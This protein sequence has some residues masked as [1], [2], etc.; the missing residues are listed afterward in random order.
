MCRE[1][2]GIAMPGEVEIVLSVPVEK[3]EIRSGFPL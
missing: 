3:R 2:V 1:G